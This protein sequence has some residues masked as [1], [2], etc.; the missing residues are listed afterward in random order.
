MSI[1]P[2]RGNDVLTQESKDTLFRVATTVGVYAV[3]MGV[4]VGL[5]AAI[6]HRTVLDVLGSLWISLLIF[7]GV[8]V[9]A[10]IRGGGNGDGDSPDQ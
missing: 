2:G 4:I 9:V 5:Y 3:V 1:P 7:L 6:A 8:V 10:A